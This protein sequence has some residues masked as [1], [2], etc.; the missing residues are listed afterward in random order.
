MKSIHEAQ[1]V[2]NFYRKALR[3]VNEFKRPSHDKQTINAILCLID[4]VQSC[5]DKGISIVEERGCAC[6]E[7]NLHAQRDIDF[8]DPA[9]SMTIVV[10]IVEARARR[11]ASTVTLYRSR[12]N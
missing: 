7:K 4:A 11:A 9:A 12:P 6:K 10:T 8:F 5:D 2:G 3:H 1:G